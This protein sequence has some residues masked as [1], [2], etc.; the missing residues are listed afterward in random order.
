[1]KIPIVTE[2]NNKGLKS[3]V[4]EFKK[5]EGA[6]AKLNFLKSKAFSPAAMTAYAAAATAAAAA[7]FDAVKAA[8][9]DQ[10]E[11]AILAQALKNTVGATDEVVAS[12]E[13]FITAMQMASGVS[14]SEFRVGLQNLTRATGD[15]KLSQE[16]LKLALDVS[17]GSGKD[18]NSVTVALGKAFNGQVSSLKKLGLPLSDA[19]IKANDFAGAMEQLNAKFGGSAQAN[20]DSFAGRMAIV[21]QKMAE[22]KESLGVLLLPA[23]E[24]LTNA[25][26]GLVTVIDKLTPST[27]KGAGASSKWEKILNVTA[28]GAIVTGKNLLFGKDAT[29]QL[30]DSTNEAADATSALRVNMDYLTDSLFQ[31]NPQ[32]KL[33]AIGLNDIAAVAD[34]LGIQWR[35]TAKAT[36]GFGS[37]LKTNVENPLLDFLTAVRDARKEI[38][39]NLAAAF[40]LGSIY[41]A[42][43]GKFKP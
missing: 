39:D 21:S 32:A 14:D 8:G 20:A 17:V 37:S 43:E 36:S 7:A 16:L 12:T 40:D 25:L 29:D 23:V 10:K 11:Q 42:N 3:A 18:L 24:N 1:I 34:A 26:G 28:F 6:G 27:L 31:F 2:F 15:L 9:E 19:T 33:A 38:Q 30:T 5:L 41:Q 22:L 35:D 13:E 4:A